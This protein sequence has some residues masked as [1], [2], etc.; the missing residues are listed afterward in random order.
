MQIIFYIS[1]IILYI[2]TSARF[3]RPTGITT[4]GINLYLAE[5]DNHWIR[6]IE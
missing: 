2:G 1:H 5:R 3:A 6:K 4:D